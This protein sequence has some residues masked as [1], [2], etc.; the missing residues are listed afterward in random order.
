[1]NEIKGREPAMCETDDDWLA[2][3]SV[4]IPVA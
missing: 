1:M 2:K 3:K 4:N